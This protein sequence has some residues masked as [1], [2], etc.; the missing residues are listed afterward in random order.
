MGAFL[1]LLLPSRWVKLNEDGLFCCNYHEHIKLEFK[2]C[3]DIDHIMIFYGLNP[4]TYH[5]GFTSRQTLFEFLMHSRFLD[6]H[7]MAI[8]EFKCSTKLL[9]SFQ[10]YLRENIEKFEKKVERFEDCIG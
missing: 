4:E 2:V 5:Q 7:E 10:N 3:E 8:K 1:G 9:A 6:V